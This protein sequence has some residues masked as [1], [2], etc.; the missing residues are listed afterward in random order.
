MSLISDDLS[1]GFDR[2]RKR[3]Q[4]ELTNNENTKGKNHFRNFL[5]DIFGFAESQEKTSF[6][7]G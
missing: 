4:R 6:G 5:K 2:D 7:L 3:R 1:V